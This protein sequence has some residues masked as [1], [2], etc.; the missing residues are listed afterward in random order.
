MASVCLSVCVY[1]QISLLL[2]KYRFKTYK[3]EW[4]RQK[5]ETR[6]SIIFCFVS[7]RCGA[8]RFF[9]F[10]HT[11]AMFAPKSMFFWGIAIHMLQHPRP[12]QRCCSNFSLRVYRSQHGSHQHCC[13]GSIIKRYILANTIW[14][15]YRE[16][17]QTHVC[18]FSRG[19]VVTIW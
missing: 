4:E 5:Q 15:R 9:C 14:Y 19:F 13:I 8:V 6:Q 16:M 1:G 3:N 7:F 11:I 2:A 17:G 18:N 10:L 12:R